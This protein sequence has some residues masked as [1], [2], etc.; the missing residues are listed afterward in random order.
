MLVTVEECERN[1][2]SLL[3]LVDYSPLVSRDG[4][5][6]VG[7]GN[8]FSSEI[9]GSAGRAVVQ[10]FLSSRWNPLSGNGSAAT[11]LGVNDTIEVE[12][13]YYRPDRFSASRA[14]SAQSLQS[15][16]HVVKT[17]DVTYA[18]QGTNILTDFT[19]YQQHDAVA[20]D[21]SLFFF[22]GVPIYYEYTLD[23][24]S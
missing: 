24:T 13:P 9:V 20:E 10:K 16:S 17:L 4:Y 12:L 2:I 15:N 19:I 22:T 14:I 18:G 6:A 23:E 8:F 11:N 21:F 5:Q 7:N 3:Q 1:F